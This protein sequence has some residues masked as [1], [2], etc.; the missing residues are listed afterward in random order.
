[1]RPALREDA[2]ALAT[3]H[4]R[5]FFEAWDEN[6]LAYLVGLPSSLAFLEERDEAVVGFI[7]CRLVSSESEVLTCAVHPA[8]R[9]G[10]TGWRLID[11]VLDEI[12]RLGGKQVFLEVAEDAAAA[13]A[14][15]GRAGFRVVGRRRRYYLRP[16]GERVD[17]LV[18]RRTL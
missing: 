18:M 11:K 14:L 7:L 4:R 16:S 17:A 3:V 6:V 15:Y 2:P 13:R 9:R 5:C 8:A 12:R 10:G 1:M